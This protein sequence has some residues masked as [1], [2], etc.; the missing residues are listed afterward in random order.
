MADKLAHMFNPEWYR[1][2]GA[3]IKKV[4]P[5]FGEK[6]FLKA[7]LE[8][9]DEKALN[10]RMR[11][12][13]ICLNTFLPL[14]FPAVIALMKRVIVVMPGGYTNLVF[15][16]FVGLYGQRHFEESMLALEFFTKYGSSEFAIR[17]FL[18][19]DFDR[20]ISVMYTWAK[21]KDPHVRRLASEGSRPRLPWSFKL[22]RVFEQPAI[23]RNILDALRDDHELYVRKSVAN[24]LNDISKFDP[25]YMLKLCSSWDANNP[26]T[27]W[28]IRHASRTLIKKGHQGSLSALNFEKAP[29]FSLEQFKFSPLK[30]RIGEKIGFS[31]EMFSKK[32]HSQKLAI[33]YR[34]HYCKQSGSSVKTFKLREC[35]LQPGAR[36]KVSKE[37]AFAD[38][39]TRR[40]YPGKHLFE[41]QVNGRIVQS[42]PFILQ[43]I[44]NS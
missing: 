25:R 4:Y 13:S 8:D 28:I 6:D 26:R 9:L 1:K 21:D 37:H 18:K 14:E 39:S 22:E 33:D 38:L 11:Q 2:L 30:V 15:P 34:I 12:T 43:P 42:I 5:A 32:K 35:E 16:D 40:H 31:F 44:R 19:R 41:L 23:T 7:C 10:E 17:Q 29:R 36:L 3:E 27:A 24:H 20:T